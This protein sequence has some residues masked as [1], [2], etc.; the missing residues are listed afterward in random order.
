M[1][2]SLAA[3]AFVL[4]PS[5]AS[6]A[7][8]D[9]Y[10]RGYGEWEGDWGDEGEITRW[11]FDDSNA[12][13]LW[14]KVLWAEGAREVDG[15]TFDQAD[16]DGDFGSNTERATEWLQAKWNLQYFDGRA[17]PESFGRA[18][19]NIRYSSGSEGSGEQLD[20]VYRGAVWSFS[21]RRDGDGT[22]SF[23]DGDGHRRDAGSTT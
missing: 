13:C 19:N 1:V 22:Y 5:P 4:S 23:Y 8:S 2:S 9:G 15:T 14:Q 21:L 16:I 17:G 6:A 11:A 20:L 18:D 10:V 12:A 7:A 3:G